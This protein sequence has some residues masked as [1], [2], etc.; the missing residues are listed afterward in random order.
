MTLLDGRALRVL[1]LVV[2]AL[3]SS[4]AGWYIVGR[5]GAVPGYCDIGSA[6]LAALGG[7]EV[8]TYASDAAGSWGGRDVCVEA[9][10]PGG[11]R[12]EVYVVHVRH[13]DARP[14]DWRVSSTCAG[15][16]A[17][18]FLHSRVI[19]PGARESGPRSR[20]GC[21]CACGH[22]LSISQGCGHDQAAVT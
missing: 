12:I 10:E 13:R 19:F 4:D 1:A 11:K 17:H 7:A 21:H 14:V 5:D 6:A 8:G 16:P 2:C 18:S 15:L 22:G 3:G 9:C 20:L